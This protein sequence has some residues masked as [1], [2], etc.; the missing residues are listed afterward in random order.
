[1]D[2]SLV[3]SFKASTWDRGYQQARLIT[4]NINKSQVQLMGVSCADQL[5]FNSANK[6][7]RLHQHFPLKI[8]AAA[9]NLHSNINGGSVRA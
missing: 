2:K 8:A 6:F 4:T 5:V 9:Q 1:L 7:L 3:S